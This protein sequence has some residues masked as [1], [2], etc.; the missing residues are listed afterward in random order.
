MKKLVVTTILGL[1]ACVSSFAQGNFSFISAPSVVWDT[2]TTPGTPFKAGAT[3][4]VAVLWSSNSNAVPTTY[5]NGLP[6]PTNGVY[7]ADWTGIF[8]D[9]NFHLAQS[10]A[11]GNPIIEATCGGPFP[12]GGQYNGGIQYINTSAVGQTIALYVIAW[13]KSFGLDPVAAA[14]AG[15]GVGFSSPI[16]YTLGSSAA[17]GG[18]LGIGGIS[19]FGVAPV[20]AVPEP[21]TFALLGLGAASLLIF[22]RRK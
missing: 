2:L 21:T 17:P 16:I 7:T 1:A 20:T 4:E 15:A 8:T 6:T 3:L 9:P 18:S 22:R 11:G 13:Q 5:R 14:A 10:T 19:S 12:A